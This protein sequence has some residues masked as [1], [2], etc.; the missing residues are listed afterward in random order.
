MKPQIVRTARHRARTKVTLDDLR[1]MV[2]VTKDFN[3][4]SSVF[5]EAEEG[6]RDAVYYYLVVEERT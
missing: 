1:A 3:G 4:E 6:Q 2:G 5:I